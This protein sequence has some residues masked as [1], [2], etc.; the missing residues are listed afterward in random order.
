MHQLISKRDN[1]DEKSISTELSAKLYHQYFTKSH[2][3]LH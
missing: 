3:N 1:K 2:L